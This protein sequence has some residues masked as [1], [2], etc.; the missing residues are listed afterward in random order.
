LSSA[1]LNMYS[2]CG[3]IEGAVYVFHNTAGKR[4]LD[5]YNATLVGFTANGHSER[6]LH[7]LSKMESTG[8]VPN[9]ITFN[10]VLNAWI[11]YF[12]RMSKQFMAL[13]LTLHIT[14]AW[15]ICTAVQGSLRRLR[16]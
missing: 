9:K 11:Q 8:L 16:T 5:T 12:R 3:F 1:L 15:W 13:S 6:A 14:V 2:K 4:S 7:L 10:S